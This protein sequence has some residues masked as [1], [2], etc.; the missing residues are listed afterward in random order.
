MEKCK[1]KRDTYHIVGSVPYSKDKQGKNVSPR[2]GNPAHAHINFR[3]LIP[4][5]VVHD[6]VWRKIKDALEDPDRL[7]CAGAVDAV[8]GDAGNGGVILGDAV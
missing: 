2:L 4:C 1:R 7:G 5:R 8:S 6:P 3:Y